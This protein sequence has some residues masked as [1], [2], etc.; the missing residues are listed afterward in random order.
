MG[1]ALIALDFGDDVPG[2]PLVVICDK[3]LLD[4]HLPLA[5]C[6]DSRG[7]G[8]GKP[9]NINSRP[10]RPAIASGILMYEFQSDDTEWWSLTPAQ[11][12]C[13]GEKL[14]LTYL[15]LGG[16]LDPEPDTQSPFYFPEAS[17]S[18]TAH[19]RAGVYRLRRSRIQSRR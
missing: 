10:Q 8:S 6:F 16:S 17:S 11:R 13:E 15:A 12:L 18:G 1:I 9:I 3:I 14:W 4:V 2:S 7:P 19:G 5:P